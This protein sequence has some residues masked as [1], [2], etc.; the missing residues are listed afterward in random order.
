MLLVKAVDGPTTAKVGSTARY[1]ATAFNQPDPAPDELAGINWEVHADG[2]TVTRAMA[3]GAR[4]DLEI[5]PEFAGRT[6]LVM[7]F[8]NSP[9]ERV[10]V[11][12]EIAGKQERIDRPAE[13]TL[14]RDGQRYYAQINGAA[15]YYVGADVSYGERRGL[16]NATLAA[17]VYVPEAYREP[18]GF[19]ADVILPTAICESQGSFHCLNTYDLAAFTFGF[20]QQ[21][22][23]YPNENFVL[24]LRRFLLLPEAAF[25]FPD[26]TLSGGHVAQDTPGGP[27]LLETDQSSQRLMDYLNPDPEEVGT[28]EADVAA[29]F[30]HWA[31]NSSENRAAQVTFT[32]EQQ[33]QKFAEYAR[34]YD[35]DGAEDSVC[36][37][38]ADIR[39]QGRADSSEI[40]QALAAA[41]PLEAL[42]RLGADRYPDRI[43]T[44]SSEIAR[45]TE[46]GILGHHSYSLVNSDFVLD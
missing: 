30:V 32:V 7:P 45:M 6:L 34:R 42:L 11:S 36:I 23:H 9:T 17:D 35:L 2:V 28:Q 3:G 43:R 16:M 15:E 29:R 37:V 33:R 24:L 46:E 14:R 41:D 10:S 12:T 26:L 1:E 21:A 19:W 40:E 5:A 25:Y 4:F 27:I 31:E 39:H 20:Y 38:V 44:L 13:V 8:A 22:A 18:F